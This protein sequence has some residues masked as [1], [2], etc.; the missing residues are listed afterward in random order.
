MKL[1]SVPYWYYS[2]GVSRLPTARPE[3][4]LPQANVAIVNSLYES[5]AE[6]ALQAVREKMPPDIE[7]YEAG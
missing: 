2:T 1:V 3:E 7:W 5:F 4:N 6:E